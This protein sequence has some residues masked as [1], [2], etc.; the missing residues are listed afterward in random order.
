VMFS[1]KF[2]VKPTHCLIM[3]FLDVDAMFSVSVSEQ[4]LFDDSWLSSHSAPRFCSGPNRSHLTQVRVHHR[5][6]LCD[7]PKEEA[8]H[9][10]FEVFLEDCSSVQGSPKQ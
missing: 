7:W 6:L 3:M 5:S 4:L 9:E 2:S 1:C 8:E 10:N